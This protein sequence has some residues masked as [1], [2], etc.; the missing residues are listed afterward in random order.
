MRRLIDEAKVSI[1]CEVD[2]NYEL[3]H[4]DHFVWVSGKYSEITIFF[5]DEP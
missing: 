2:G 3:E 1:E 5:T 4:F